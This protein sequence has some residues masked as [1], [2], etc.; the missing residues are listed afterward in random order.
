MTNDLPSYRDLTGGD[1]RGVFGDDDVLGSL[2][3][4]TLKIARER[5]SE[6][7]LVRR[8]A[9]LVR[10]GEVLSLIAPLEWPDPRCATTH[11]SGTTS[12][13]PRSATLTTTS[14]DSTPQASTQ[15]E[16]FPPI[17]DPDVGFCHGHESENLGVESWAE[18]G[19]AGR[20]V[21]FDMARA[22]SRP[23]GRCAGTPRTASGSMSSRP[24]ARSSASKA[25]RGTFSHS[26]RGGP[27][28]RRRPAGPSARQSRPIRPLPAWPTVP[29]CL[30]TCGTGESA[31]SPAT[32]S[33]WR[34]CLRLTIHCTRTC[35]TDWACP[36]VS[37]AGGTGWPMRVQLTD[38]TSSS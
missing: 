7:Y 36:S 28:V 35:S 4:L 19:I 13:A 2:N 27:R 10:T 34:H 18:S 14:T 5:T 24:S 8:A 30:S 3:R 25:S 1:A 21:L 22:A 31:R 23:V 17:K 37:R 33:P 26:A 15:W 16:A 11:R 12:T 38:A 20:A 32:T 6:R 29:R 9:S